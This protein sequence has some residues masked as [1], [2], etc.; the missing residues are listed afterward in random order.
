MNTPTVTR[1]EWLPVTDE[2]TLRYRDVTWGHSPS[3]DLAAINILAWDG[4]YHQSLCFTEGR[5]TVRVIEP[6]GEDCLLFPLGAGP[7]APTLDALLFDATARGEKLVFVCVPEENMQEIVAH[8]GEKC[9]VTETRD[10][11]DYLYDAASLATLAGKKLHGKRGH[12]NAFCAAHQWEVRPLTAAD[13]PACRD[14]LARW[15]EG[16]EDADVEEEGKA[17]L[18]SI[19]HFDTLGLCGILLI[20]DGTPA[21]FTIG[22][23]VTKDTFCVHFEKALADFPGAY[24]L[25]AREFVRYVLEKNP[26]IRFINREDDAGVPGLRTSKLSWRPHHL[27]KKY[28]IT[29]HS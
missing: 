20:A 23:T 3:S 24:P 17:V 25:I 16:R 13:F 9:E 26:E 2:T 10:Y 8:W 12:I 19:Q 6:T 22:S 21:A 27:L 7:L 29:V 15:S 14:I 5:A 11:F 18:T 1:L 28:L 4:T